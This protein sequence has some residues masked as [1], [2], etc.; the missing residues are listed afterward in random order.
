MMTKMLVFYT[1]DNKNIAV[2]SE[3]SRAPSRNFRRR[4]WPYLAEFAMAATTI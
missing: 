4:L 1:S 3:E 2:A